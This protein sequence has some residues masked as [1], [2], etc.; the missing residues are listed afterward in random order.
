[1]AELRD[2]VY[3][4][5]AVIAYRL[6]TEASDALHS[7]VP[8]GIRLDVEIIH[9]RRWWFDNEN[10]A[11]RQ[12]YQLEYHA[13]SE[14]YIVL[15]VNSGDQASFGSL[16]GALEYLGR[17]ER[18]PLIDTAVLDDGR[19]YY[20]R[21]RAVARRGAVSRAIAVARLLA[22]RLVDRERVVSMAIAKRIRS[23]FL[24]LLA[25]LG[26]LLWLVALL[27]FTRVTENSDDFAQRQILDPADQLRRHHGAARAH[28]EQPVA[29]R[30][31][32]PA[33]R[34]GLAAPRAHGIGARDGGDHAARRRLHLLRRVHQPRHRQLA[35]RRRRERP[36]RRARARPNGARH[37]DAR[38]ARRGATSSRSSSPASPATS[39][40]RS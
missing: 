2:G 11:L 28:R 12:S 23:A 38:P 27:S 16:F 1:M 36:R 10:A 3:F 39:S 17:V 21:L 19:G 6:S 40:R 31:R 32:L 26:I 9:P 5:N 20:V 30:A 7:G 25:V 34:A 4:L 18:L 14:R 35:Q 33:P 24:T 8:L 15:N 29:A 22:A 37:P 13:L